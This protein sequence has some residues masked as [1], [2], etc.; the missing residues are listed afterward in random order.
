MLKIYF[1]LIILLGFAISLNAISPSA[2]ADSLINILKLNNQDIKERKLI[3]YIRDV[4]QNSPV[5]DL[6][7][8]KLEFDKLFSTYNVENKATFDYFIESIYQQRI[9]QTDEA[10][11]TLLKAIAIADQNDD[12]YLLYAFFTNLGFL[13]TYKGNTTNAISSFRIAK[14]E[15][16][17]LKDANLQVMIDINISDIYYR[18]NLYNQSLFYLTQATDL[19]NQFHVSEQRLKNAIYNNMAENYF[20]MNNADSL[21]KYNTILHEVK[22]GTLRLYIYRKRTDYYLSLLYHDY[23]T[24]IQQINA[25]K[26]DSRYQYDN[27]DEQ[28]LADAYY[29]AGGLDSAKH[30]INKLL[31]GP[32]QNNHPEIKLHLYQ[33]LGEI[34]ER[35]HNDKQA[36]YN[37]KMAFQQAREHIGRLTQVGN[38]S[39]EIKVDEMQGAYLHKEKVYQQQ[40]LWLI[41]MM[42]IAIFT[43]V[44]VGM[45]YRNIKQKRYYEQMLFTAKKEQ[46][47][48]INSHEVRRH[49]SNI[50]GIVDMLKHSE[51][52]YDD[53]LEVEEYLL[54][55]AQSLDAAIKNISEKLDSQD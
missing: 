49:L 4:W 39:T 5:S 33:I 23:S 28:N 52:R 42:F 3:K 19:I 32:Q 14:K 53:Y 30:I 1:T 11:N 38:I 43:L 26:K 46:L 51:N 35:E 34:A 20:L 40:R 7:T 47:A 15:A 25:L 22:S 31:A 29:N 18:N 8:A 2:R 6:K 45:F 9:S 37:F 12:H 24:A 21:K 27:M 44:T 10:E 16:I 13:Q 54:N 48:F 55:A 41:L 17:T 36:S 50:L